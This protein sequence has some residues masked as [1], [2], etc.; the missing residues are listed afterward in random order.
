M[1]KLLCFFCFFFFFQTGFT[2]NKADSLKTILAAATNPIE[3]FDLYSKIGEEYFSSGNNNLDSASCLKMLQ[4]AQQL[5]N[6]S[7]LAISYN[8]IGNIFLFNTGDYSKSLEFFFKGIPLAQKTNDKRRLSSLY[9]DISIVY[10]NLGNPDEQIRYIRK[11][12]A[13]LPDKNSPMYNYMVRQVQYNYS[14]YFLSMQKP[15]SAMHYTQALNE[16]NLRF[17]SFLYETYAQMLLGA[18]HEQL[19]DKELAGFHFKRANAQSDS[20]QYSYVKFIIKPAFINFLLKSNKISVAKEQ[21]HQLLATGKQ[22]NNYDFKQ[23]A[24]GFLRT[25]YDSLRRPDTAYY[26]ARLESAFRDSVFSKEK[27][28]KIQSLAFSEQLRISEEEAKSRQE[29]D[30]RKQN[31]QYALLALGII[32]FI[33][34]FLLLSRSFITNTNIIKF[35][36]II[37]LLIVFEFLNLLLHPFLERVTHHSPVLMLLALVCIAALL[38]PLHHKLE[39]WA[40]HRLV[41]KNKQIRLAAARKTIEELEKNNS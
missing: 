19:G 26:Y 11:A 25:V 5:N 2:Q 30:Q 28:N 15:D 1:K 10:E 7:L 3:R 16:T 6:D 24:A 13:A 36:G 8:F 39:K 40:T 37:T 31:I 41:E 18:V 27:T 35:L 38:V 33:L 14:R 32:T 4:I 17:R 34:L 23:A 21:A 12:E 20:M 29:A 9:I 22:L